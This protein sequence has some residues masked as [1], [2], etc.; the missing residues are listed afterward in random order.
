M[1]V[2]MASTGSNTGTTIAAAAAI[3]LAVTTMYSLLLHRQRRRGWNPRD[4]WHL[5]GDHAE[6]TSVLPASEGDDNDDD[7]DNEEG[8]PRLLTTVTRAATSETEDRPKATV[9]FLH[10]FGCTALEF[11][12]LA[13][14]T[15]RD[16]QVDAVTIDRIVLT[17]GR[18]LPRPRTAH[19]LAREV[20]T[21]LSRRKIDPP[22]LFVGHSYGGLVAQ[23]AAELDHDGTIVSGLVLLDPAHE[24]QFDPDAFPRDFASG[25]RLLPYLFR[26]YQHVLAP[27]GLLHLLDAR[28]RF[29]FPPIHLIQCRKTRQAACQLYANN[30]RAWS[31]VVDEWYGCLE[32]MEQRR[33]RPPPKRPLPPGVLVIA[34]HRQH[35]PTLYPDQITRA[36]LMLFRPLLDQNED[37][38]QLV[39]ADHSDHWI[40]LQQPQLVVDAIRTVI[41]KSTTK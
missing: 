2:I 11:G 22:Y 37:T 12:E 7:D 40:H 35:S 28:D 3:T 21:V 4:A 41:E 38:W 6:L 39:M 24:R 33:R 1:N 14:R 31:R 15:S 25:M 5:A 30:P 34:N 8:H 16:L 36:F 20:L 19:V 23:V 17:D 13:R 29:I 32:T 26:L 10:G 27:L 9:V 18:P